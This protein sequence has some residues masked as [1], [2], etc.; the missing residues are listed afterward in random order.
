M[1]L[2]VKEHP[3]AFGKRP[4]SYYKKLLAIP[5]V[6]LIDSSVGTTKIIKYSSLVT[7]ISGSVGF[8]GIILGKPVIIF[9]NAPYQILPN[10]TVK[11]AEN[12]SS[13]SDDINFILNNFI[14]DVEKIRIFISSVMRTSVPI[15][16]YTTLLG[17]S[18]QYQYTDTVD[19]EL[20]IKKLA[21]YSKKS[22]HEI[23]DL[24]SKHNRLN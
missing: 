22:F 6:E 21:E 3:A 13:L 12:I 2:L 19:Y 16:F 7:T 5:N 9:G 18:E 4:L 1:K 14:Y 23:R 10:T 8:E 17:R 11:K 15:D 24:I 20:E